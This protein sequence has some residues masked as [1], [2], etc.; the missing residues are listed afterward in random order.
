[1]CQ[2]TRRPQRKV[3]CA[4]TAASVRGFSLLELL[5]TLLV[6]AIITSLVTLTINSGS[7]DLLVD[8]Q[9]RNLASVAEYAMDEAQLAGVDYG[10]VLLRELDDAGEPVYGFAWRERDLRSWREP[11]RDAE[12]FAEQFFDPGL[13]LRLELEDSPIAQPEFGVNDPA[14]PPQVLFYASGETTPGALEVIRSESN[15]LLWR[16]EWDLLGRFTLLRRGLDD[17]ADEDP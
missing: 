9:V 12:V 3:S 15:D 11:E 7:R 2:T 10:M 1:M 4:G 16:I 8:S 14:S 5:V 13:E 17:E 6:V